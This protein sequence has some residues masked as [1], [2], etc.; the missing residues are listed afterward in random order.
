VLVGGAPTTADW[1][2]EI[3]ADGHGGDA[4]AAVQALDALL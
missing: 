1:A 4:V 2:R 3:G